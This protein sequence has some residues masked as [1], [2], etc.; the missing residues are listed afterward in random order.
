MEVLAQLLIF[1]TVGYETT[2]STLHFICYILSQKP[3]IQNK[4]REE[5]LEVL[6]ERDSI[7]YE[8]MS[9][10]QY[11]NQVISETL[12]MYPPAVRSDRYCQKTTIIKNIEIEKGSSVS[13]SIYNIHHDPEYYPNPHKFDP[14]RFSP[15]NKSSRHPMAYI[16]FGAGPR[17]C[18]GMRFAEFEIRL[19]LVDLIKKYRL[20]PSE[21]MPGLP[22]SISSVSLLKPEVELKCRVERI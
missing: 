3:D 7:D 15:E 22:I 8:D 2:A 17:N 6:N 11:M 19:T 12:R 9:K 4:L 13:F 16:P 5:I 18:I 20:L 14:E 1:L 10:L 21:G